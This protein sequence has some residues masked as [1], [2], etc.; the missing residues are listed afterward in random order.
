MVKLCFTF[1]LALLVGCSGAIEP[2]PEYTSTTRANLLDGAL[3]L[4][5]SCDEGDRG[6]AV[7]CTYEETAYTFAGSMDTPSRGFCEFG[8]DIPLKVRVTVSCRRADGQ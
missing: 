4:F 8:G 6:T 2:A 5:A 3:T 1:A 7:A